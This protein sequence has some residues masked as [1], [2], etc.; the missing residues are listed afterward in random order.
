MALISVIMSVHNG[1]KTLKRAIDSIRNQTIQDF[2]FIIC[3]DVSTDN[4]YKILNEYEE[5]GFRFI[6]LQNEKN[7]GLAVSL[8]RCLEKSTGK[9][10]AR[11]DD[12]DI[13]IPER[14]EKQTEFLIKNDEYAFVSSNAIVFDGEKDTEMNIKPE[15]PTKKDLI[16]GSP[17]LHPAVMF[18]REVILCV[19]GYSNKDYAKK[20]A[21]DYE[22]FMRMASLNIILNVITIVQTILL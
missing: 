21:Q 17:Y 10:I 7:L 9:Y 15:N 19:G 6:I 13:S 5:K 11:M 3:D 4:T 12:D 1:E 18:R 22:L 8:N 2:E 16:K 14:F 20:R